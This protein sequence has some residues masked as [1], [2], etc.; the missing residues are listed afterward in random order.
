MLALPAP[1]ATARSTCAEANT[2]RE[3]GLFDRYRPAA[4]LALCRFQPF[5]VRCREKGFRRF[6]LEALPDFLGD[7][8]DAVAMLDE[9][10]IGDW[11]QRIQPLAAD[12]LRSAF[13]AFTAMADRLALEESARLIFV[14]LVTLAEDPFWLNWSGEAGHVKPSRFN[15]LV[16]TTLRLEVAQVR[17]ALHPRGKLALASLIDSRVAFRAERSLPA[18]QIRIMNGLDLDVLRQPTLWAELLGSWFIRHRPV[19]SDHDFP[20][21]APACELILMA[22]ERALAGGQ[23]GTH[24]LLY[25]PPGTGKSTLARWFGRRLG[26]DLY[27]VRRALADSRDG[28]GVER[29]HHYAFGQRQGFGGDPCLMLFDEF[30][31]VLPRPHWFEV[32]CRSEHKG[33]IC[34]ALETATIPTIWITNSLAGIDPAILRRF[35]FTLEVPRPPQSLQRKLLEQRL[36]GREIGEAWLERTS[37]LECLTPAMCQQ[38]ATLADSLNLAGKDLEDALDCWLQE[39]LRAMRARPLPRINRAPRFDPRLVNCDADVKRIIEGLRNAGEGRLCLHGP[40]GTG[41]TAYARHLARELDRPALVRRGSDLRSCWVG[42]TEQNIAGMFAEATRERSVLILDEADSFLSSRAD[43]HWGWEQREVTE[44]LV[45][46]EDYCGIFVATTNRFDTLD[47]AFMRRFDFKLKLGYL[48]QEQRVELFRQFLGEGQARRTCVLVPDELA[49]LDELTPGDFATACR[50]LKFSGQALTAET[51]L[52][53]LV[54]E[55]AC[56]QEYRGRRIG[57]A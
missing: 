39:R 38:I 6:L 20:H 43:R 7:E 31:D 5:E 23:A 8:T 55:M 2:D 16:A 28:D 27:E 3:S 44:F 56:K 50:Q 19:H 34:E 36:Q 49:C 13:P 15:R 1:T 51:L 52:S 42:E 46:L 14:F 45:Q 48:T 18:D 35:A 33:W 25:G 40:P 11:A 21:M 9:N 57:F 54:H 30:E 26:V 41:K 47:A 53:A 4:V 22:M 17:S 10:N 32:E 37:A 29:L 12:D 24:I